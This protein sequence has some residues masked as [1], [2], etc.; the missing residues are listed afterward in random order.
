MNKTR[1]IGIIPA[2]YEATRFPGKPLFP[3]AGK[4]LIQRVY[5]QVVTAKRLESV[6]VATD[7]ERIF[8][9]V[10]S[11]GGKAI[12]TRAD[13]PTGTDRLAEVARGLD[14]DL[15]V[16]VQGDE[17][18]MSPELIDR[19]VEHF[20]A[21]P[22]FRFGSAM[23]PIETEEDVQNPNVV[24]VVV[25]QNGQALYFTR[26]PVPYRRKL[27]TAPVYQHIGFYV[28]SREF[29][30][31]FSQMKPTPLEQTEC[32]EQLRALENGIRIDMF[33]TDYLGIGVDSPEDVARIEWELKRIGKI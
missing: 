9:T 29:L 21:I 17:P 14:C 13:H 18:L 3:I 12:M 24:K 15:V 1:A 25:G 23:T 11:F 19:S 31:D 26:F 5:E 8:R 30:I 33:E 4:P 16:N 2:R 32:L 7:D 27:T 20:G 22:D 6:I 28:Y 10:E